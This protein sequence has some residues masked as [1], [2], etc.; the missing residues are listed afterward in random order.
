MARPVVGRERKGV[1][2]AESFFFF[3]VSFLGLCL[4]M[5]DGGGG[6]RDGTGRRHAAAREDWRGHLDGGDAAPAWDG[7]RHVLGRGGGNDV[8]TG[9]L[10]NVASGDIRGLLGE[11]AVMAARLEM[12]LMVQPR[13]L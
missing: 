10:F 13:A 9:T 5:E 6:G 4:Q 8:S 3:F 12:R 7:M 2:Q 1:P 11:A